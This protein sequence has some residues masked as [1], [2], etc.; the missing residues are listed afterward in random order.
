MSLLRHQIDRTN[1][2][3]IYNKSRVIPFPAQI[4]ELCRTERTRAKSAIVPTHTLGQTL[5][6]HLA[7]SR[8]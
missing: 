4:A 1:D 8:H 2:P 3:R 5:G 7:L 6:E